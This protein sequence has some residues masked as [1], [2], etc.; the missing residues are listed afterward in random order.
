MI[1]HRFAMD[2]GYLNNQ[3][4][5][6]KKSFLLHFII[7]LSL[8][9]DFLYIMISRR[10]SPCRTL[11]LDCRCCWSSCDVSSGSLKCFSSSGHHARL[12]LALSLHAPPHCVHGTHCHCFSPQYL[13]RLMIDES[14]LYLLLFLLTFIFS[15]MK[16]Y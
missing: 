9:T 3:K 15:L 12:R 4:I 1:G 7:F 14:I 6:K 11:F 16:Q 13:S 2:T 8:H 10:F 5:F